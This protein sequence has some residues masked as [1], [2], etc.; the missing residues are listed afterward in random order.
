MP[1]HAGP[2][3]VLVHAYDLMQSGDHLTTKVL[4][5]SVTAPTSSQFRM[6]RRGRC[7]REGGLEA[8]VAALEA[9]LGVPADL[10]NA[11]DQNSALD[12]GRS[13]VVDGMSSPL[14]LQKISRS[15][16]EC[17]SKECFPP[18]LSGNDM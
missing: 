3:G 14:R 18:M 11:A 17:S 6:T 16:V 2:V 5:A 13:S 4:T 1:T 9:D 10:R 12:G 8:E 15:L 7:L